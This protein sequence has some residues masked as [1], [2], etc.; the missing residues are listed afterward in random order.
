MPRATTMLGLWVVLT[1]AAGCTVRNANDPTTAS[2][3]GAENAA[4][5]PAPARCESKDACVAQCKQTVGD[6]ASRQPCYDDCM[7]QCR[8]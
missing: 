1:A 7:R 6:E 4:A 5:V 3:A 8:E 2:G